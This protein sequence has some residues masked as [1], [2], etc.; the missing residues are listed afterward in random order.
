MSKSIAVFG[1]G[2]GLGEAVAR[3]FAAEGF[4]VVLVARRPD[5]LEELA[6]RIR[7]LGGKVHALR[8]DLGDDSAC[9]TLA[10]RVRSLVGDPDAF[11]YGPSVRGY[12]DATAL[13]ADDVRGLMPLAVYSLIDLAREFLPA[14]LAN[15]RGSILTA[16]AASALQGL[17][18]LAG[19]AVLAAQRNYL[20]ALQAQVESRGVHVG[21]LY[22]GG[23]VEHSA[24]HQQQRGAAAAGSPTIDL[25]LL[26]ADLLAD[27]LWRM[28]EVRT[29]NEIVL[30]SAS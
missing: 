7:S 30:P 22:I 10:A 26:S 3:R 15:G 5:P 4:E 1:A 18:H 23:I 27:E 25:P 14:M 13:T 6:R 21:R 9:A 12:V 17:P 28:H 19:T 11:Y 16:A 2:P 24:F 29:T 20:Q 8:A